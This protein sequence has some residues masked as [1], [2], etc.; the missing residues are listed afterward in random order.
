MLAQVA[1][2]HAHRPGVH[3]LQDV[4]AVIPEVTA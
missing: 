3:E 2:G 1:L 4:A